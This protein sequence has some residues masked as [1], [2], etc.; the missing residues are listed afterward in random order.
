MSTTEELRQRIDTE[1]G[2]W[3]QDLATLTR[4]EAGPELDLLSIIL[5]ALLMW[6]SATPAHRLALYGLSHAVA[7]LSSR[8]SHD[9]S[10]VAV[11]KPLTIN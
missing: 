6:Q 8:L 11:S 4:D 3:L 5:G 9:K 10:P 2:T 1:L 7:D